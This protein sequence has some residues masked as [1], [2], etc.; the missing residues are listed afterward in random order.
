MEGTA[1]EGA[2]A[3]V[4]VNAS[5]RD[6][7]KA[8]G[9]LPIAAHVPASLLFCLAEPDL[10]FGPGGPAL[11][12]LH[13]LGEEEGGFSAGDAAAVDAIGAEDDFSNRGDLHKGKGVDVGI[14]DGTVPLPGEGVAEGLFLLAADVVSDEVAAATGFADVDFV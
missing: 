3:A 10:F 8:R 1:E 2:P 6:D 9:A 5:N 13:T 14:A 11:A 7:G 4:V 12:A